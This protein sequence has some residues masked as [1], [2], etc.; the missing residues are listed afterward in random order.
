[1]NLWLRNWV[2]SGNMWFPVELHTESHGQ[3]DKE[4]AKQFVLVP[5]ST[6]VN[7]WHPKCPNVWSNFLNETYQEV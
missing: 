7:L 1:M 2:A 4:K 5:I 6:Q 3:V